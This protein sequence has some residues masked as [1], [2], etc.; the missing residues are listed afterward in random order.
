LSLD[1]GFLTEHPIHA[2]PTDPQPAGD[3][4]GPDA[5]LFEPDDFGSLSPNGW[6]TPLIAAFALGFCDAFALAL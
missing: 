5:R 6:H 3:F 2:R 1:G 4:L